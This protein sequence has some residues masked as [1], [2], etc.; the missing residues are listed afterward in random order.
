MSWNLHV[1]EHEEQEKHQISE[2][3]DKYVVDGRYEC[4][5]LEEAI[6][7]IASL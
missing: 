5:S 1:D 2:S 6:R 4:D 7:L 3:G